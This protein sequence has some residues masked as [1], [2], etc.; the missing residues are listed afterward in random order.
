MWFNAQ[1][2]YW[3]VRFWWIHHYS[4]HLS[5]YAETLPCSSIRRVP[6][7]SCVSGRRFPSSPVF[8]G[9]WLFKWNVPKPMDWEKWPNTIAAK[10]F[11]Y[12]SL[13]I[14]FAGLCKGRSVQNTSTWH[15]NITI[16]NHQCSCNCKRRNAGEHLARN[17]ISPWHIESNKW[18]ICWSLW[19]VCKLKFLKYGYCL[20]S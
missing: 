11:R 18:S 9:L 5:W 8:N 20:N 14:F 7:V 1:P 10:I 6:A 15:R 13:K 16:T 19:I 12:H 3:T 2:D 17:W 4:R